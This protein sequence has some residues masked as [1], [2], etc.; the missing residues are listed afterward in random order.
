MAYPTDEQIRARAH[1]LW[2]RAGNPEGRDEEFW[3]DAQRELQQM[4]DIAAEDP[5]AVLPG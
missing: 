2:E 5:S 3:H 1:Q 4:E